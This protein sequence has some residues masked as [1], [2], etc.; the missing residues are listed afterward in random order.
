MVT[1]VE[2]CNL[3]LGQALSG[4]KISALTAPKSREAEVCALHYGS[5]RDAVLESFPWPFATE[6]ITLPLLSGQPPGYTY[7]YG[8]PAHV[9]TVQ[10]IWN[11]AELERDDQRIP[12]A[13]RRDSTAPTKRILV[14]DQTEAVAVCTVQVTETGVYSPTFVQALVYLLAAKIALELSANTSLWQGLWSAYTAIVDQAK[15]LAAN[16]VHT[17][18]PVP[19]AVAARRF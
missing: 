16:Q 9:L 11:G 1:E 7:K 3:A 18:K 14:T 5:T 2:I 10:R 4:K 6:L 12:Y 8:L 17:A 13:I 15:T 19:R